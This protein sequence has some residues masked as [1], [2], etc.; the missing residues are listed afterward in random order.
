MTRRRELALVLPVYN[1]APDI[2]GVV[3]GWLKELAALGMDFEVIVL[4]D[5]SVDAT[6]VLLGS[7]QAD[8]RVTLVFKC[9]EGHGPTIL[10][11]YKLAVDRAEWVFQADSD[12][13]VPHGN[14]KGL[15]DR[16]GEFDALFGERT[17]RVQP[18]GRSMVSALARAAVSLFFG[19]TIADVNT[20]YRLLRADVLRPL[21]AL[22]PADTFAPNLVITGML[23]RGRARIAGLP[24]PSA[25]G[26]AVSAAL[27]GW[28]LWSTAAL[29]FFQTVRFRLGHRGRRPAAASRQGPAD[30]TEACKK[31]NI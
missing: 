9:N 28:R 17:G 13:E 3:D 31:Q 22:L 1:G 14:F 19:G 21:L 23:A 8:S 26:E 27:N 2:A 24:V 12:N 7:F 6:R 25:G 10:K 20:P 4:D 16:R 30:M 18:A 5:G 29:S 15:W 11:G